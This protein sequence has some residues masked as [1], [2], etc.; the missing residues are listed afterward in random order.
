MDILNSLPLV[1]VFIGIV[2][3]IFIIF[4]KQKFSD[5]KIAQR[6][7][8]ALVFI[9]TSISLDYFLIINDEQ[10]LSYG[11]SY[12]LYHFIGVLILFLISSYTNQKINLKKWAIGI[13]IFSLIRW[14]LFIPLYSYDSLREFIAFIENSNYGV[15]LALEYLMINVVNLFLI[16]VA[17][18]KLKDAP[19]V[20]DLTKAQ[21]LQYNWI[22]FAFFAF[23]ILNIIIFVNGITN[24]FDS[25]TYQSTL[26]IEALMIT[27]FFFI[28]TYSILHFPVF[29]FSGDFDDLPKTIKQKYAKSS[30]KDSEELFNKIENKVIEEKLYL[31]Y[32]IKLNT[33]A[34]KLDVSIHHISQAIN[35]SSGKTFP[36]FINGFRIEEAKKKLAVPKPDTILAISLDVGFNSKAAF[37]SAF[38]KATNQTPSEFK[39]SIKS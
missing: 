10:N 24:S 2:L 4:K 17:F 35:Q 6:S 25:S 11:F 23:A 8:I 38:K 3:L 20:I 18:L 19:V 26:K 28:F 15:V 16:L 1:N 29:A 34:E 5:N 14:S 31:E 27:L 13:T 37:Y 21:K 7:L 30:L 32:D 33:L 22:R 39:K 12:T 36:D 9:Y